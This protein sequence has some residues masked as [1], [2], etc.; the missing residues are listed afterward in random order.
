MSTTPK[1][2]ADLA[3]RGRGRALWKSI[4][5]QLELEPHE[6]SLVHAAAR[7]LDRLDELDALITAQGMLLPDGRVH[8]AV[9]EARLQG[10]AY[11]RL[12][13]SL[14]L[15]ED[16]AEPHRRPQRRGASRGIYLMGD[17]RKQA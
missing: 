5:E 14:R 7:V 11:S 9:V 1:P 8:P 17:A 16:L 4:T 10:V 12:I 13:A 2:P 6:T 3:V 15:P